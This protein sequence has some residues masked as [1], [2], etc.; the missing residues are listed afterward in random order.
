MKFF[1][2]NVAYHRLCCIECP[3]AR[4]AAGGNNLVLV[5]DM[6]L[7]PAS[8]PMSASCFALHMCLQGKGAVS[9]PVAVQQQ[10]QVGQAAEHDTVG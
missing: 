6:C 10:D 1:P 5:S 8:V 3:A 2:S 9:D 7:P 4:V